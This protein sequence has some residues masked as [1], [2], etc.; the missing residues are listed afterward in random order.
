MKDVLWLVRKTLQNT[1]RNKKNWIVYL[2]LPL[3]GALLSML[4]YGNASGGKLKVGIVNEDAGQAIAQ[5]TIHFI[6]Q[7]QQVKITLTDKATLDRAIEDGDLDSGIV[8]GSGFSDSI[9]SGAPSGISIK[10]IK[11]IQVTGYLK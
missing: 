7:L 8:I 11:G 1:F 3:V 6:G 10:S 4:F 2:A 9:R 5:D